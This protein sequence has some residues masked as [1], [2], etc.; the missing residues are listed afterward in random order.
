MK[1]YIKVFDASLKSWHDVEMLAIKNESP[2]SLIDKSILA[3]DWTQ[4]I[5]SFLF[6]IKKIKFKWENF[7]QRYFENYKI[8]L[9]IDRWLDG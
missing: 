1:G 3:F 2:F 8:N 4:L 5:M 9:N 7:N 6:Y